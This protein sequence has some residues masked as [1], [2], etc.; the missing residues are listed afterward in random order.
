[1]RSLP[2]GPLRQ[3]DQFSCGAAVVVVYRMLHDGAYAEETAGRFGDEVLTTHRRLL[4]LRGSDGRL[5][6][7]WPR[8]LGTPPWALARALGIAGGCRHR[9]RWIPPW[10]RA[11]ALADVR[12]ALT[13]GPVA[14]YVGSR[15]LPRHVLLVIDPELHTYDPA[16][17]DVVLLDSTAFARPKLALRRWGHPWA[18]IE[19]DAGDSTNCSSETAAD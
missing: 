13:S 16:H 5:Q 15:W 11:R 8:F 19:T 18:W 1:M 17:G 9:V 6:L 3:P 4:R 14:V 7:P 10:R 12:A 2:D